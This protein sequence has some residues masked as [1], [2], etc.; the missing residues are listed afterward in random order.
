[1]L[2]YGVAHDAISNPRFGP[3]ARDSAAT[4][5][6]ALLR[7]LVDRRL[8]LVRLVRRRCLLQPRARRACAGLQD[9]FGWSVASIALAMTIG[10]IVAALI[11][12]VIGPLADRYGSRALL[13]GS[14][15]MM[16]VLL[17]A[18]AYVTELWQLWLFYGDGSRHRHRD[19]RHG[20]RR[21]DLQLVRARPRPRDGHDDDRHPRGDVGD[22][23]AAG[24][25]AGHWR[26]SLRLHRPRS[27][28][29]RRG[30]TAPR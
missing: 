20:G 29:R 15:T 13:L 23:A 22:A 14:V 7:R 4:P 24:L 18:M 12:P 3:P 28:R 1:M 11:A 9:E 26:P 19:R 8:C 6:R 25:D 21:D 27:A 16:V 17:V 5:V 2:R 10:T 30:A